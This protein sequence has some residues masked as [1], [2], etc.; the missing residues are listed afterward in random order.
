MQK[1]LKLA[2]VIAL[3]ATAALASFKYEIVNQKEILE[4]GTHGRVLL[5]KEFTF[6]VLPESTD[7][8]TEIWV[9]LPTANTSVNS[10]NYY[11][12]GR[13]H[14]IDF[15][16]RKSDNNQNVI[17]TD[18]PAILP[19]ESL[20]FQFYAEIPDLI[21]WLNKKQPNLPLTE[22]K[23]AVSY[24]PAWWDEAETK[25]LTLELRFAPKLDL[26]GIDYLKGNPATKEQLVNMA[27]VTY[28]YQNIKPDTKLEHAIVLPKSYFKKDFEPK[29]DW[30]SAGQITLI[31]SII[32][33]VILFFVALIAAIASQARYQTPAAY[34]TGKEA[35]TTFDPVE[36]ALF[37]NV[38][39]D[40]LVKL[41]V[42]GLMKKNIIKMDQNGNLKKEP[43]L[44]KLAWYEELFIDTID[45]NVQVKNDK[46]PEFSKKTVTKLKELLGGYCGAQTSAYYKKLLK[47]MEI[48]EAT[49]PRWLALKDY[50]SKKM[51]ERVNQGDTYE[52]VYLNSYLPLFYLHFITQKQEKERQTAFN[53]TFASTTAGKGGTGGGSCACA[54]ACACASSGGCT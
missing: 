8:G 14:S 11:Q 22:Q 3:I 5:N 52:P 17:F 40:L 43:T 35:C 37:F 10:V 50:L 33:L 24:I 38:P 49:D 21:Y 32:G 31:A 16:I 9:G 48:T 30:L 47:E 15:K 6:K 19:G 2:L 25:D 44:E 54:C 7:K 51:P 23:V 39:G 13:V 26:K 29:K 1:T 12:A 53:G 18:F 4:F 27:V 36:A 20:T 42:M 34:I 46:W 28:H 45:E 41:I